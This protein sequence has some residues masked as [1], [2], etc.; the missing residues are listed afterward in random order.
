MIR[1]AA[2]EDNRT[3]FTLMERRAGKGEQDSPGDHSKK[4]GVLE[5]L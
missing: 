2:D 4:E 5:G 1:K 3:A